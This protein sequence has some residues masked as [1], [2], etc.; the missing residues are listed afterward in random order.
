VLHEAFGLRHHHRL[1]CRRA[2][3]KAHSPAHGL[4]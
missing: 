4:E 2:H 1:T 3:A